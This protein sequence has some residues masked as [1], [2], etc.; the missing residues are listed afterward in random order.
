MFNQFFGRECVRGGH[1]CG[2]VGDLG[3]LLAEPLPR[4]SS[5]KAMGRECAVHHS[6]ATGAFVSCVC[7]IHEPGPW[8]QVF[9]RSELLSAW[10]AWPSAWRFAGDCSHWPRLCHGHRAVA[11]GGL[12]ACVVRT[13]ARH[14]KQRAQKPVAKIPFKCLFPMLVFIFP[15]LFVVLHVVL[16][17]PMAISIARKLPPTLAVARRIC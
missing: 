1:G 7:L 13:Q 15:P 14:K 12:F 16:A 11:H 2:V 3:K 6:L 4:R 8:G 9:W 10:W 5:A 17:G